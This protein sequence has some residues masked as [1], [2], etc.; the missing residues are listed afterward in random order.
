M[1]LYLASR[2][3][4]RDVRRDPIRALEPEQLTGAVGQVPGMALPALRHGTSVPL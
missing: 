4:E 1:R 2:E 3:V